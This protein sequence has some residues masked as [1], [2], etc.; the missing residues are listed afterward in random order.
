MTYR[1]LRRGVPPWHQFFV[2]I[3]GCIAPLD[4]SFLLGA[5]SF[6][7]TLRNPF[8]VS[9]A[10]LESI[11]SAADIVVGMLS[12]AAAWAYYTYKKKPCTHKA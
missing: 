2:F 5:T 4:R 8:I 11:V 3:S 6:A 9:P 12:A 1:H 10:D 7:L